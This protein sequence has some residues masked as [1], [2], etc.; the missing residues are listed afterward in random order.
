MGRLDSS[1]D[2]SKLNMTNSSAFKNASI[3]KNLDFNHTAII[4]TLEHKDQGEITHCLNM[5]LP[6]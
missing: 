4:K 6:I 1:A 2:T 5:I 3:D